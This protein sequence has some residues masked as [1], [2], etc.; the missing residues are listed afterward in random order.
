MANEYRKLKES[1]ASKPELAKRLKGK[2]N[3]TEAATVQSAANANGNNTSAA[4]QKFRKTKANNAQIN[5]IAVNV[6]CIIAPIT[7]LPDLTKT[8]GVSVA[9][10]N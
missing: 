7:T 6:A 9:V 2:S 8:T 4:S 5:T 10:G 1:G 3:M